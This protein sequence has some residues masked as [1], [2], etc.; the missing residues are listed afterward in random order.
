M[1]RKSFTL[2]ELLIVISIIVIL[3]GMIVPALSKVRTES[4]K[5]SVKLLIKNI[6][7]ACEEHKK[8]Y[9]VY[10]DNL[11]TKLVKNTGVLPGGGK[12]PYLNLRDTYLGVS[13]N[14]TDVIVDYWGNELYYDTSP[15]H[16]TNTFDLW[17]AGVD[18]ENDNGDGDDIGNW[19]D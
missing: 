5:T 15:T 9:G 17:S 12:G 11:V 16:N 14:G 1:N 18:E 10:P 13:D 19:K 6:V 8:D 7:L 2:I 3:A 4:Q